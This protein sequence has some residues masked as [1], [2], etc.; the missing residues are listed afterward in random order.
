MG[1]VYQFPKKNIGAPAPHKNIKSESQMMMQNTVSLLV[2]V[3][4][5]RIEELEAYK[6]E[7]RKKDG[8]HAKNPKE[9]LKVIKDLNKMFYK[10]GITVGGYRFLTL[11]E[12]EVIYL[13]ENKLFYVE[14]KKRPGK[15]TCYQQGEFIGEFEYHKFTL[16]LEEQ[17]FGV[18]DE[19]IS[20]LEVTIRTLENT[21]I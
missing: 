16:V 12:A 18:L 9:L 10:Y 15:A 13:N 5:E 21:K 14:E 3:Y 4:K 6:E 7:I 8:T 2:G 11:N 20:D 17:L 1:K 19:R